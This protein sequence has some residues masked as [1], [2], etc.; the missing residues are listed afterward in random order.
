MLYTRIC[1]WQ[2]GK[3]HSRMD[4]YLFYTRVCM[5]YERDTWLSHIHSAVLCIRVY[6][7]YTR[8]CMSYVLY[9]LHTRICALYA[10]MNS[11]RVYVRNMCLIRVNVCHTYAAQVSHI[12]SAVIRVYVLC[13][14]ICA[15]YTYMYFIRA[16]VLY[17]RICMYR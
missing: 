2:V 17:A 3:S 9:V 7:L 13:T 4:V 5:S 6:V 10:Y 8:I 14:R 16:Y 15:L 11:I 12:Q 1:T